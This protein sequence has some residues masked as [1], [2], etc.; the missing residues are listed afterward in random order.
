MIFQSDE[1]EVNKYVRL[2]NEMSDS[3]PSVHW[4]LLLADGTRFEAAGGFL[5]PPWVRHGGVGGTGLRPVAG[6]FGTCLASAGRRGRS[7]S[8]VVWVVP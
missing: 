6:L 4:G 2:G 3:V 7:S 8:L 5:V 1:E